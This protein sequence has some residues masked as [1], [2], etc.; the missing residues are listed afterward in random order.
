MKKDEFRIRDPFI[1]PYEGVY[2]MFGTG[3]PENSN[4][5]RQFWCYKSTDLENWSEPICC[6]EA[7][8]DF[9]GEHDFWAPEVHYY[10]GKFYMLAS[11]IAEG[12]NRA[13]QALMADNPEG[14][15]HVCGEPLTPS[16][17]M[18][19]DG[20]LYVEDG[21]PYL[22]FCH[23]WV[24]IGDG[25]I[26][27]VPLKE[28]LS[29][30]DGEP[31]VLFKASESGW[32]QEIHL[33]HLRG[34]VTDGPCL[35]KEETGKLILF[36]SSFYCGEY[37]V[38]IA[39][40]ESGSVYGPWKHSDKLL[41]EKDGGHGMVFKSYDGKRYFTMHSPNKSPFERASFYEIQ[42]IQGAYQLR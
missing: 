18:S 28:D 25:E 24:Q 29:A 14:P 7:P 31:T 3:R 36:W 11:F 40:S 38:G 20:T 42:K 17:W 22:V 35:M 19:L 21:K 5:V 12:R 27:A 9:W 23:E 41:F 13:T 26:V 10:R 15:Y 30:A 32:A 16:E 34:V 1:L 4:S 37:A 6:F 39:E 2:Y 33:G 8:A